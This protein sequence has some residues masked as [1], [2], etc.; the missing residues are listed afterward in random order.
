M[1]KNHTPIIVIV[2]SKVIIM[3]MTCPFCVDHHVNIYF[4]V[5]ISF[6]LRQTQEIFIKTT[7]YMH[8][9]KKWIQLPN[10]WQLKIFNY[11]TYGD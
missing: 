9:D 7:P 1:H 8:G 4:D 10:L 3:D 6:V 2:K 11:Q 5:L